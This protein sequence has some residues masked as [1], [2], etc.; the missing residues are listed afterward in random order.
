MPNRKE[1]IAQMSFPVQDHIKRREHLEELKYMLPSSVKRSLPSFN[2]LCL[3]RDPRKFSF[4]PNANLKIAT[5][6]VTRTFTISDVYLSATHL[7]HLVV[8]RSSIL[9]LDMIVLLHE[10]VT[11]RETHKS[12]HCTRTF[13]SLNITVYLHRYLVS[14]FLT[15]AQTGK[16]YR[17]RPSAPSAALS[18]RVT[19]KGLQDLH[20]GLGEGTCG[21]TTYTHVA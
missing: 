20:I 18:C 9:N 13:F 11:E 12:L 1:G 16:S 14:I 3:I 7:L 21:R 10:L 6:D 8:P 2:S 5:A 17:S 19:R 4:Q 15:P